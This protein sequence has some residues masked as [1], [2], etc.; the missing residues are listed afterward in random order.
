MKGY[1]TKRRM[2]R[3]DQRLIGFT[4]IGELV[5]DLTGGLMLM[6][7]TF[8]DAFAEAVET[9]RTIDPRLSD[10]AALSG[11][12]VMVASSIEQQGGLVVDPAVVRSVVQHYSR[13]E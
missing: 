1:V 5:R 7:E 6:G 3:Q 4:P 8:P 10:P 9:A 13:E 2:H 11:L 12:A